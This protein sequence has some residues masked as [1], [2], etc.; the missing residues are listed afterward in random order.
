MFW[1]GHP[2]LLEQTQLDVLSDPVRRPPVPRELLPDELFE[3]RGPLSMLDPDLFA[4]NLRIAR[5][6]A[7]GGPSGMT[8]GH[9]RPLLEHH[10]DM[11]RFW[12]FAQDLARAA[13]PNDI[14]EPVRLGRMTALQKPSGGVRGI[15]VDDIIR[16]LVART[17][18]K[19]LS[20]VVER[21]TAPF[22]YASSTKSG[23]ECIFHALQALTD[24]DERATVLSIH[25][26]GAFDLLSRGSRDCGQSQEVIQPC[27][28]CCSFVAI[29]QVTCGM[30]TRV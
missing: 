14:A 6:G 20:P 25:H 9:L 28:L 11:T 21:A 2:S 13:V 18:S 15:V 16:R 24:L 3:R 10:E 4:K 22:Q 1:K 5:R 29:L 8:S 30:M 17:I 23:G 27:H 26:I 19:Q 7:A 12:R